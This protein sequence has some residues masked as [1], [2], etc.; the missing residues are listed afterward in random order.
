[1]VKLTG[2]VSD[3]E[4]TV[5]STLLRRVLGTSGDDHKVAE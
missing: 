3:P 4:D 1:M 5:D 2:T